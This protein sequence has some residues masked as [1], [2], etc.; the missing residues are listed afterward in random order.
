LQV[1]AS[2]DAAT[3]SFLSA[4]PPP[5]KD[6]A[7]T[8]GSGIAAAAH[9]AVEH[10]RAAAVIT[11]AVAVPA[12]ISYYKGRYAGY[13]GEL[14][15]GQVSRF[16]LAITPAVIMHTA[17]NSCVIQKQTGSSCCSRQAIAYTARQPMMRCCR[18][19]WCPTHL[20]HIRVP[21][22]PFMPLGSNVFRVVDLL[23]TSAQQVP[24]LWTADSLS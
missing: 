9:T 13:A 16:V 24:V 19:R 10:P 7:V 6:A 14:S 4:L 23:V 1:S 21:P 11:A 8:V 2:V 3:Q 22:Y 5:V 12:A 18:Q 17:S 20:Y 15:P